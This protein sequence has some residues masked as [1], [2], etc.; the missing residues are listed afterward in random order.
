VRCS[1]T[2][3]VACHGSS[4][5]SEPSLPITSS[6]SRFGRAVPQ[7]KIASTLPGNRIE[8]VNT[9]SVPEGPNHAEPKTDSGSAPAAS[10]EPLTQ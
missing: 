9:Q 2:G 3:F 8:P 1:I 7:S 10:R 5:K 6:S 4:R